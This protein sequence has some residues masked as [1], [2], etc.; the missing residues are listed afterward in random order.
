MFRKHRLSG[1]VSLAPRIRDYMGRSRN[2]LHGVVGRACRRSICDVAL[3]S[4][5]EEAAMV[6]YLADVYQII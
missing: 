3:C 5:C 6:F 2:G 1:F 4:R